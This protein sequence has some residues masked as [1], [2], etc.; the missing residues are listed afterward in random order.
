MRRWNW[1]VWKGLWSEWTALVGGL[2]PEPREP[3]LHEPGCWR[4][5]WQHEAAS[6]VER[7]FRAEHILPHL[8]PTRRAMLRSQS[9]PV[10]GIP[11]SCPNAAVGVAVSLTPLATTVQLALGQEFWAGEGSLWRVGQQGCAGKLVGAWQPTSSCATWT[12]GC[13]MLMTAEGS[14]WLTV[15]HSSE[16]RSLLWTPLWCLRCKE[17]ANHSEG[18]QTETP[19]LSIVLGKRR[20]PHTPSLCV[21]TI[22]HVW[23]FWP[24]RLEAGGLRKP[25]PLCSCWRKQGRGRSHL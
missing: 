11:F 3:E 12:S 8:T 17:M 22:E 5:G 1:T 13:P 18:H 2:R 20:R 21:E 10:A 24:W 15:C 23:W 25:G 7:H 19:W 4:A 6:R 16:V 14:R 9:G